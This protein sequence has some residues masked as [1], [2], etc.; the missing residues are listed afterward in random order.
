MP[1][2]GISIVVPTRDTRD[3]TLRGLRSVV[4]A[5][6]AP[7]AEIIL[8]D[9]GSRDGTAEAV[10]RELPFTHV[11]RHDAPRGFSA[12]ANAGLRL[13]SHPLLLLLNSDTEVS[14]SAID[15]LV[16]AFS[17]DP[18]LGIAGA[19]LL[20]PDGGGQWSGGSAPT[21][22]WLFAES[23][24]LA[25]ALAHMPGYRAVRPLIATRDRDVDWVT[26]AALAMRRDVWD[27][28][29]PFDE[30]FTTYAQDLDFCLRARDRGWAVRIIAGCRVVH[31][32]GATISRV[33][34]SPGRQHAQTL[35]A[36]LI[37]WAEKRRGRRYA[38]RAGRVIAAG[39][40]LR[41]RSRG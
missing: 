4:E 26:G 16:G 6:A 15:A 18:R 14:R 7:P 37:R 22:T 19:Q 23:S 32:H 17:R 40:R 29:G 39:A 21:L 11:V 34:G 24:G 25:R 5:V 9:D 2:P 30:A 35:W 33:T 8:V 1:T 36:D 10:E 41:L 3:L 31:H 12:A 20:Y 28:V 38:R 13:A 27:A